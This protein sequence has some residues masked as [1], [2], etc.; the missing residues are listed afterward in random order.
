MSLVRVDVGAAAATAVGLGVAASVLGLMLV[1]YLALTR[2]LHVVTGRSPQRL[3]WWL[4]VPLVGA[5]PVSLIDPERFY[6][7]LLKPSLVALWLSQLI[8][9]AAYPRFARRQGSRPAGR[10]PPDPSEAS[11][12]YGGERDGDEAGRHRS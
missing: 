2:L 5:G 12:E 11:G 8:V 10:R 6:A 9:V 7:D 4:A 1:E 3:A